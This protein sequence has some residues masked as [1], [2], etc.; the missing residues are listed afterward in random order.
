[1]LALV[2]GW[3]GVMGAGRAATLDAVGSGAL[4]AW[5]LDEVV[6]GASPVRRLLGAV[7]L[8]AELVRLFG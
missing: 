5:A 7:V 2:I 3:T 8:A 6:R 1:M 4:V